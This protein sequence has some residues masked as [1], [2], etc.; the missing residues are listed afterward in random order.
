MVGHM[1]GEGLAAPLVGHMYGEGLVAHSIMAGE[2][3]VMW[4]FTSQGRK[5]EQD[6]S[7]IVTSRTGTIKPQLT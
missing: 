2:K 6:R 5:E 3:H 4:E 1:Y 7:V